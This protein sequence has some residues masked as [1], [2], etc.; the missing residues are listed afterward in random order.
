MCYFSV[1]M[2]LH[3]KYYKIE[4]LIEILIKQVHYTEK[5]DQNAK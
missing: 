1:F 3:K 2:E 5:S 4:P